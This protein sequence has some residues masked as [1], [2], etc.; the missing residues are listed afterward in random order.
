MQTLFFNLLAFAQTPTAGQTFLKI[1]VGTISIT[2]HM[3]ITLANN[4]TLQKNAEDTSS[5]QSIF[6]ILVGRELLFK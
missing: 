1:T 5:I 3:V 4:V 2:I 6:N